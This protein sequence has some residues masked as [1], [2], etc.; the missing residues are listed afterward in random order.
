MKWVALI[1]AASVSVTGW[2][3]RPL[4]SAPPP[5]VFEAQ[6]TGRLPDQSEARIDK[7]LSIRGPGMGLKLRKQLAAAIAQ[8]SA[9]AK[10]DPLLVLAV[11]AV[12]SEFQD[13]AVSVVG[14]K[15]L[16]QIHPSTLYFWAEHEGIRLTQKEME[17]DPA[18]RVRIG[19]RYLR[20]LQHYFW[21][22]LDHALMAYNAGPTRLYQ[23][24]REKNVDQ[25]RS[26]PNAVR[27]QYSAL[28]QVHGEPGDWVFASRDARR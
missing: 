2:A 18:L 25:F 12:E 23:A 27:R 22:D 9:A 8:E 17:A 21:G 10:Y 11:I 26:Y 4:L 19:I 15:G 1:A 20:Y 14:A 3:L 13:S 6:G 24:I 28:R 5:R 16:M 7:V